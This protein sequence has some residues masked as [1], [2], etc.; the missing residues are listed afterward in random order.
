[1]LPDHL[2]AP[3][4]VHSLNNISQ[5][6]RK[7]SPVLLHKIEVGTLSNCSLKTKTQA[8]RKWSAVWITQGRQT[9]ER[10][11]QLCCCKRERYWEERSW[12]HVRQ[13]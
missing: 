1:L 2:I 3:K 13:Q 12:L 9:G 11:D 4:K 8:A 6:L 10:E 5:N 7:I